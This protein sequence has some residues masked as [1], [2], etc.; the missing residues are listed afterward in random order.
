VLWAGIAAAALAGCTL[1]PDYKRPQA[2]LPTAWRAPQADAAELTNTAWWEA[3][4][5]PDLT[6]LIQESLDANKDLRIAAFRVEEFDAHLQ[7]ASSQQYPQIGYKV[8]GQRIRRS[9]EVPELIRPG[10][11]VGYNLFSVGVNASW[12][13]DL[14]GRIK[15]SNEAARAELLSTE[16]ARRA[17]MLTV[18]SGVAS[19]YVQLL[20]LDQQ[21]A[22][23]QQT[24]KNR[25]DTLKL[26][27]NKQ[28]GGS[29][30][31]L[32]VAQAR[33]ALDEVSATIPDIERQ[34]A[35]VEN[36][37][38]TLVGR[39][40]GPIKRG[41]IEKLILPAVPQGVP[42]DVLTRRPD[43]QAAEQSLV[44]A[45]ARIGVAK[46]EYFPT[47]S[48]T[49][50][51][52]LAS[53]DLRWLMA[54]TARTGEIDR[55]VLGTIFSF[56]RIE[57]DVRQAEAVQKQLVERYLQTVQTALHEVDDALIYR[58]KAGEHVVALGQRVDS[59]QEVA[60]LSRLRYQ[61]GESTYLEV[62]D[63]ER[64]VY[65]A[66]NQQAQGWR[67]Q[68]VALISVYKAMGGGWM[69]EQDKLRAT[70]TGQE[71]IS[72]PKTAIPADKAPVEAATLEVSQK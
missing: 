32:S 23:T 38:S 65:A 6:A 51:L 46:T 69:V 64:Q 29:A 53:D 16:E 21:L 47:I 68:Y 48:L 70:K 27:Q 61:G 35:T 33:S 9:Q 31:L 36:A 17:V 43:V 28:K 45:N 11:P 49:A 12:E 60:R 39:N 22:L 58:L 10:A 30:T 24:V 41:A 18:V 44:A 62:L 3:F 1:G 71:T 19:S 56:G 66:Q 25:Q 50:A 15:R 67:E 14:W 54:R 55:N 4:K 7:I 37:L 57:G 2:P 5:D 52:G 40:P 42:S 72:N 26:V 34:I 13:V 59:Q 20:G 8:D 63:A